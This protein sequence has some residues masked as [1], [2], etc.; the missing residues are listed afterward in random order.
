M[1]PSPGPRLLLD[2]LHFAECPR[3]RDGKLW[4]ADIF[5]QRVM[6]V[7]ETGH[8]DI[9]V[10]F[11]GDELPAGLGFLPDGRL[12]MANMYHPN[13]LR[14]DGPG[15]VSVHADVSDLAVGALNDMVVDDVG[16]I[17][18]GSMGTNAAM[19]PRPVAANGNIIVIEPDGRAAVVAEGLDAPNGPCISI[20]GTQYVVAE[21]PAARLT[22]FDRAADGT[23]SN[24]RTWAD[25]APG[26]ADGI[27]VDASGGVWTASPL[28][29]QCR[30]IVEGGVVTNVVDVPGKM[31]LACALGGT[32]G[33][34]LFILS[35]VGSVEAIAARTN[36]SVIDVV[37]V[38]VPGW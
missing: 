18:V 38:T 4:F 10:Q 37:E 8:S 29:S 17:Y 9:V 14:L 27:A 25:L 21:F 16:R 5:D 34:T 24:R 2:G 22:G 15:R 35:A 33:G 28:Q 30:R 12:L 3:W 26:T 23:L 20:D 36:T 31:P 19:L 1:P 32:N 11:E 7:D 6:T 13:I